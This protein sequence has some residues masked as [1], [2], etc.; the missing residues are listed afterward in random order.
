LEESGRPTFK[1]KNFQLTEG[2]AGN[3]TVYTDKIN[4]KDNWGGK[5]KLTYASG[6]FQ[7]YGQAAAMGLVANGGADQ[8]ITFT[9]WKLKDSGSGNQT[10]FLTGFTFEPVIFR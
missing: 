7:W 1:R 10:N 8:T 2:T 4:S 6:A 9:G 5:V 3:Y